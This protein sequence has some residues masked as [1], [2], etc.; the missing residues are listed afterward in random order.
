ML[1]LLKSLFDLGADTNNSKVGFQG[2]AAL[3]STT[4]LFEEHADFFCRVINGLA[5]NRENKG[6]IF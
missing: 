1:S 2:Q 4:V 6:L 5:N 3:Q